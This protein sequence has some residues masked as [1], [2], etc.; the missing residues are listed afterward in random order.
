MK[1]FPFKFF[2]RQPISAK[3][4]MK[5]FQQKYSELQDNQKRH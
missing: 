3:I 1:V 5:K 4:L 2:Q